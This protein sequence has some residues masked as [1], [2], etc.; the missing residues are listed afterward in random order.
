MKELL[1]LL[2]IGIS[3][4]ID[5]FSVS[6][7]IGV[8]GLSNKKIFL[9]SLTVGIFHFIMPLMGLMISNI[10]TSNINIKTNLVLGI[11]LILISLQMFIECIKPSK[12]EISLNLIGIFLFA[13]G[14]S[15]DSFS[16]GLGLKAITNKEILASTIFT[17]CSFTLTYFGFYLGKYINL[18]LKHF[19]YLFG[20]IALLLM[21][22]SFLCK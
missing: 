22:I 4:S 19:S 1:I 13:L 16:V 5:A 9:T 17:L 18:L 12:K 11:V 3:L 7:V 15:L 8:I 2:I 20:T 21:G 6:S 14:V 10:L